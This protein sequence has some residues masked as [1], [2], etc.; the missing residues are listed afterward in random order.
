MYY[1]YYKFPL[2]T[3]C[4]EIIINDFYAAI[5]VRHLCFI[6]ALPY[7]LIKVHSSTMPWTALSLKFVLIVHV[8]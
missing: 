5:P 8:I 6:Y 4:S 1:I 2:I 3:S 7:Y